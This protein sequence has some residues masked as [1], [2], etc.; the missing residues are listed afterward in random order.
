MAT[1]STHLN[2]LLKNAPGGQSKHFQDCSVCVQNADRL[3]F[4]AGGL[5]VAHSML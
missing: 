5:L 1:A 2:R 4:V 3:V